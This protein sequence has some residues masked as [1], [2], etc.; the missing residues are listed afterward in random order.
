MFH[1][2]C[3]IWAY[4]GWAGSFFPPGLPKEA[5]LQSY[6]QRLTAVEVNA[7]FYAAPALSTAQRWA[8]ETPED[9]RFCPK[10]P[11]AITH[12][13][14]LHDVRPQTTSFLGVMRALGPRLGPLMLQLP[15]AFGP[16]RLQALREFLLALPRDLAITIEVRHKDWFQPAHAE[17]LDVLLDQAGAARICFDSRPVY[18]SSAPQAVLAQERKPDVPLIAEARAPFVLVRYI[19]SPVIEEN[20]PY[21]AEWTPR[22]VGWLSEGRQVYFFVHCPAEELSPG[23]ARAFHSQVAAAYAAQTG[24][25]LPELPWNALEG[26]PEAGPLSQMSLF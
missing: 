1:I 23:L 15:P 11:K 16:A 13:A 2:G 24:S 25:T 19:S 22:V 20:A 21:F 26:P 14:M 18:A 8:A 4:D 17:A 3:A 10:F 9:F 6:A 7:T 12:T 5:R